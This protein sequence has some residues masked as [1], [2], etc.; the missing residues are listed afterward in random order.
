[1]CGRFTN[2]L[3]WNDI[4]RL[5][6]LSLDTPA[7]NLPARYNICPTDQVDVVVRDGE[8]MLVP[9]RWGMVPNWWSKPL[10]NMRVA[11]FNARAETVAGKPMFRDSFERRRCLIPASGYYEWKNT[12]EG[13]QPYYFT[14]RDG[15]PLTFAGLWDQW[16]ER[17]VGTIIKSCTMMVTGPNDF[18]VDI[19]DRMP[20]IL[21]TK[22]FEQWEKGSPKDAACIDE[23]RRRGRA[24]A[25]AGVK[26]GQ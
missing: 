15:E 22:D 7:R 14:R 1:M 18:A 10:K 17:P 25:L 8:R 4:V 3:T 16:H 23:A 2:N 24:P 19:H 12:P 26:A 11:T 13:K 5:Y 6:R 9:M 21:E 20:V